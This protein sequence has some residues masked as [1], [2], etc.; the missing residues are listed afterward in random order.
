MPGDEI[1]ERLDRTIERNNRVIE[2]NKRVVEENKRV[3]EE[4]SRVIGD[5]RVFMRDLVTRQERFMREV[6]KELADLREESRAQRE[7]LLRVIDRFPPPGE[8]AAGA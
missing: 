4:N 5:L 7:A 1:L 8:S 3:V 6:V 2:E